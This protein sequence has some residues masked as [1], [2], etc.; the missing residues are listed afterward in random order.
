MNTL[1]LV[2]HGEN[3]ANITKEFSY[4][5][6][7]YPLTDKGVLQARQTA[8]YFQDK[9]IHE[10]YTSPLKRAAQTAEIIAALL[11]VQPVVM[12]QF[13]EINVGLLER[14]P[15]SQENWRLHDRIIQHW[16]A[17][18]VEATFPEGENYLMLLERMWQGLLEITR[19]KTDRNIIVVGHGGIFAT[20]IR[21]ICPQAD[22]QMLACESHNCCI[23][24]LALETDD[25]GVTGTLK[26]W[27][28]VEHLSGEAAALVSG[29][30]RKAE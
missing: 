13:R 23:S 1:Y 11:G 5:L 15:P 8:A 3:L 18:Q 2:R 9:A 16:Y 21:V 27:A 26:R 24:E 19:G 30:W 7:D 17:G 28:S 4:K 25:S 20:T 10:V 29:F 6:V 12:E 22:E 14:Q